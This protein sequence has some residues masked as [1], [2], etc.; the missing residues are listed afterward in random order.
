MVEHVIQLEHGQMF[1]LAANT[2]IL[3]KIVRFSRGSSDAADHAR[4]AATFHALSAVVGLQQHLGTK[5]ILMQCAVN[6][7]LDE[8]GRSYQQA[9]LAD[10]RKRKICKRNQSLSVSR[11]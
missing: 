7:K 4:V 10:S 5:T 8:K 3:M 1:G 6:R 2:R 11:R 9:A